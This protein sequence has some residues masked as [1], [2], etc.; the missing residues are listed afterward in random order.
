M[1]KRKQLLL[2]LQ[3]RMLDQ[4]YYVPTVDA[5]SF[6]AWQPYVHNYVFNFGAQPYL[7]DPRSVWLDV[8]SLPAGR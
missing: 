1:V 4:M 3:R 2:D 7:V 5:G 6:A 8:K